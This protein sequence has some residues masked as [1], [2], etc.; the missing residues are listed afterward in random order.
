MRTPSL[1]VTFQVVHRH[2]TRRGGSWHEYVNTKYNTPMAGTGGFL[3]PGLTPFFLV[4]G[5]ARPP[6]VVL[7][8]ATGRRHG[9]LLGEGRRG[10]MTAPKTKYDTKNVPREEKNDGV[11]R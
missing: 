7:T 2:L 4:S 8:H 1:Y 11:V 6:L 3:T 5:A 9:Y 10:S